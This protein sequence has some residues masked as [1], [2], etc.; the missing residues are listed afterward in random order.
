MTHADT[1]WYHGPYAARFVQ[2]GRLTGLLDRGDALHTYA[3]QNSELVHALLILPYGRDILSPFVN[4]G[5]A[6]VA[7]LAAWCIGRRF[8]VPALS[9]LGVVVVLGL[10]IIVGT[11]PGQASNDV[12]AGALLLGAIALLLEGQMQ[13]L[14]IGLAAIAA[15]L[16]LGTKLTVAAPIALLTVGIVVVGLRT[17]RR[18]AVAS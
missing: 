13:P 12:A 9:L 8:G 16:A 3:G 17:R 10:P 7:L 4:V 11:H 6:A 14:P 2:S 15:G 5:W 18:G 1:L